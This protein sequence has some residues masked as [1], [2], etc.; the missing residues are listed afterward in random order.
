MNGGQRAE[1]SLGRASARLLL[2]PLALAM[3]SALV[4]RGFDG[5]WWSSGYVAS[6]A[7]PLLILPT[8]VCFF[9]VPRSIGWTSAEFQLCPLL[10]RVETLPWSR[11]CSL[12]HGRGDGCF[13]QGFYDLG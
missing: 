11:L 12:G 9:L 10:G 8:V 6:L 13:T 7:I 4:S 5:P 2:E 1:A 3:F